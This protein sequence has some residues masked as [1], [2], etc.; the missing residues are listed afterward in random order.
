MAKIT[1]AEVKKI[2][3]LIR[4]A[5]PE[6][7]L[8]NYTRQLN[9]VLGSMDI[10]KELDT[11]KVEPTSQT[12]GLK[13]VMREDKVVKGLDINDYQNRRNLK[14]NYFVVKKVL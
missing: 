12:H 11:K 9:T 10:L 7:E 1:E 8:D 5:I 4:I 2:A 6:S 14:N 3:D 13:D